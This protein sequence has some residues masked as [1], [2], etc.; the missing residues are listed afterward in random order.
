M[1]RRNEFIGPAV[2][3]PREVER[4]RLPEGQLDECLSVSTGIDGLLVTAAPLLTPAEIRALQAARDVL[5]GLASPR[6]DAAGDAGR[7]PDLIFA[8]GE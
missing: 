6:P 1:L 7:A 8:H 4:P 2:R 5:N 3:D